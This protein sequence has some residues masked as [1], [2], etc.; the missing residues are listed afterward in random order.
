MTD[1]ATD[2]QSVNCRKFALMNLASL[3]A[4]KGDPETAVK[5]YRDIIRKVWGG[6]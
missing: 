3:A 1:G 5:A 2:Q 6:A 4:I